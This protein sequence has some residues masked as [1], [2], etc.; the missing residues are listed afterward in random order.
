MLG[1]TDILFMSSRAG[2]EKYDRLFTEAFIRPG[3][4]P[5]RWGNR[6][7]Y[8]ALNVVPTGYG[9]MSIYHAKSGRRYTLRTDGF[10]SI[11]AGAEEGEFLTRPLIFTGDELVINYSTAAAGS[12]QVEILRAN[13]T[14]I[15]EFSLTDCSII[16][17]DEIEHVVN[18]E[19]NPNLNALKDEAV[20]L[21]FVMNEAD[22]YSF[23]FR[24][25][26]SQQDKVEKSPS[27]SMVF[28]GEEWQRGN[29][30]DFG[31]SRQAMDKIDELMKK[32]QANGV[33]ARNGYLLGE[34]NYGAA[35]EKQFMVQSVSKSITSMVLGL[36]VQDGVIPS[37]DAKVKDYWHAFDTTSVYAGPYTD[38]IT[39]R[40]LSN[41]TCGMATVRSYGLPYFD[42]C[43]VKPGTEHHYHND[44]PQA[45]A[46][47]LTYL[48]GKTL[49]EVLQEKAL[50]Y[51]N[52]R[53][54]WEAP[55]WETTIKAANGKTVAVNYGYSHTWWTAQDIA[56]V[57]HLYLNKG[58]WNG[59]QILP[60]SFVEETFTDIP[61]KINPW[62][63]QSEARLKITGYGL[64]WWTSRGEDLR[65][66]WMGGRGRQFCMVIPDYGIVITKVN[67]WKPR[68]DNYDR[69]YFFR[70]I[71][72]CLEQ[73]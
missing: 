70:A 46:R 47:A 31:I 18:W 13:G 12:V 42:P 15:K 63:G 26:T 23:K 66:W 49:Q 48:Y 43:N 32:S 38:E 16:V 36:A 40:Q 27:K 4:N 1:S 50:N 61:L 14:P 24:K 62:F 20:R 59:K 71:K 67:D 51:M 65:V 30:E 19:E 55:M 57:G 64:A 60:K 45:L 6:A 56:R 5:E 58:G 35:A 17:G 41:M 54:E 29:P 21:R 7:N 39:F 9:E 34:W 10:I 3:L 44:P 28:P 11:H 8:V 52:A 68:P 37:I 33:L 2:S 22:L 73:D 53:M 72:N 69:V 25:S